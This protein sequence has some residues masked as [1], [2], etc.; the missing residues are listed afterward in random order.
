MVPGRSITLGAAAAPDAS[1]V[2]A[3]IATVI[4]IESLLGA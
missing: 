4:L 1:S 2:A 3:A